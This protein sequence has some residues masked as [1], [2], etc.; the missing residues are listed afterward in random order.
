ML[1][2][3]RAFWHFF[4]IIFFGL[5]PRRKEL[6]PSSER[7]SLWGS[8]VKTSVSEKTK[9]HA[10]RYGMIFFFFFFFCGWTILLSVIGVREILF[11][12]GSYTRSKMQVLTDAFTHVITY[13]ASGEAISGGNHC[14]TANGILRKR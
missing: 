6:I 4:I 5:L 8:L 10:Y 12:T 14:F 7:A 9:I 3:F 1:L 11:L 13:I 2:I